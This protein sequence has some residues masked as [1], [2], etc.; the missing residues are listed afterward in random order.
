M[1]IYVK[2]KPRSKKEYVKKV[3]AT[4]YIVAVNEAPDSGKAN[5]ALI[6]SLARYF[7]KPLSQLSIVSGETS[8][9]KV[10][11]VPGLE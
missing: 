2:A 8:H 1:K 4:H 9:Q 10:V 3:D 6:K 7:D 11:E 5:K